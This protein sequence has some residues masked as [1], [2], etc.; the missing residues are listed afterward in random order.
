MVAAFNLVHHSADCPCQA[1]LLWLWSLQPLT[2][3]PR[4][5]QTPCSGHCRHSQARALGCGQRQKVVAATCSVAAL[6]AGAPA[7]P[8]PKQLVA[9]EF[10]RARR[11]GLS[12]RPAFKSGACCWVRCPTT[13]RT[14]TAVPRPLRLGAQSCGPAQ[15]GR[16]R[17]G[18]QRPGVHTRRGPEARGSPPPDRNRARGSIVNKVYK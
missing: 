4:K 6:G 16:S 9:A 12:G 5:G 3:G 14:G 18:R 15:E 7:G 13:T 11:S 8:S 10:L 17:S 1:E 2:P